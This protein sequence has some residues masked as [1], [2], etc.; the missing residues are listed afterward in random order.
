MTD[1]HIKMRDML[2]EVNYAVKEQSIHNLLN[3]MGRCK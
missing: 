2:E 1:P 3:E